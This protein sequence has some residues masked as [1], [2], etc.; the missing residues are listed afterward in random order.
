MRSWLDIV[1]ESDV[2]ARLFNDGMP[3]LNVVEMHEIAVHR[4]GPA[5]TLRFDLA[6][7]PCNAPAAWRSEGHNTLQLTLVV[8]GLRSFVL[9]GWATEATG[10]LR[11]EPDP[12]LGGV[13]LHFDSPA[14]SLGAVAERVHL[15]KISPYASKQQF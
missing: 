15:R 6:E 3:S 8:S 4:D 1:G 5:L 2:L 9:S 13:R 10:P 14:T 7:F 12:V 11:I